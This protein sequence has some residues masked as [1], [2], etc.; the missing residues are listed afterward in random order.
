VPVAP[1][2]VNDFGQSGDIQ[3]LYAH[4]DI[5]ADAIVGAAL[6]LVHG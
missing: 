1:L 2:G 5:D 6:D 4:F 3:D